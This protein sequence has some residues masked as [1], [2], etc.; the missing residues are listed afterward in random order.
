MTQENVTF[1]KLTGARLV[2]AVRNF[3][4]SEVGWKAK[5]MFAGL[6]ALLF[7]IN[8][9]NVA[10]S[11]VGRDFMTAIADR[12]KAEFLRQ[13]LLYIGVFAASTILAVI[14]RFTEER[15]G[16][17][18]REFITK[19]AI[20]FYLA[21]GT[22]YRLESTGE[23]AN[24]D[25]RIA[26]D[27][28]AFTVTTLSFL[29]MLLN[30]SFTIV[31]FSGVLWSISPLL[32]GVA[33]AYAACGSYLT[34]VLGRPLVRLNYDQLDKEANFRSDLIHVRENAES[35]VLARREGRLTARLLRRLE[36]LV[37]NLRR[38][39]AVNRNLGFFT[40][41][42]NW[43]I[44]IIPALIV[45]PA[46]IDGQIEF[47]VITQS[48]MA[49]SLLVGAFSLIITQFQSISNFAAVVARLN[50]LMDAI[51]AKQPAPGTVIEIGE[52]EERV[53]YERLTLLSSPD[54]QP[55]L[56]DLSVSI[57]RGTRVLITGPNEAAKVALFRATAGL[58]TPG[59]G[60]IMRPKSDGMQFLAERPYLP[61]V[62]LRQVLVR[63][64]LDGTITNDQLV[65]LLRD[66]DLE[67][68]LARAGGLD[69]E[70]DWNSVLSLSEQQRIAFIHIFLAAPRFVF[71]DRASTALSSGQVQSILQLL[72]ERSITY[73]NNGE[74][75]ESLEPY[76]AVV[77]ID[78]QGAWSWKPVKA[79]P[80][81]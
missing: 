75:D 17:L 37:A 44:Q 38:I 22:Y 31:A 43:M 27:I 15:L 29:L 67:A 24:P 19:R 56:R 72:S 65:D 60:R 3:A 73:I 77:E 9:M 7:G 69:Q 48:A 58:S 45:A 25:Q 6:I 54:G 34:I 66:L 10:N 20:T 71:L 8:G 57:P 1:D 30:G 18:W 74:T 81:N 79:S 55:L 13:A 32:F 46:F 68:V 26:E 47:G 62:T 2:R 64:V 36:D 70:Q 35:V 21:Q 11:Y 28:K 49:F 5:W 78:E 80:T 42:Y 59:A 61:P 23:L 12:N 40:T 53:S 41:G 76:D 4:G 33:V 63:T 14:S 51:E 50:S 16:L 52:D 39:I